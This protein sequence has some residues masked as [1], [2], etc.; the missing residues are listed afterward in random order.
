M[1]DRFEVT[2]RGSSGLEIQD[3]VMRRPVVLVRS[4][5]GAAGR[6]LAELVAE[7]LNVADEAG[8]L[9]GTVLQPGFME[10]NG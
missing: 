3:A 4:P 6:E 1:S 5:A 2:R 8:E 7:I 9:E 10:V